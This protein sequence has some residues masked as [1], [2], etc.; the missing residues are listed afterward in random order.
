MKIETRL[1][2]LSVFVVIKSRAD[3]T[4]KDT[5]K[6]PQKPRNTAP[7]LASSHVDGSCEWTFFNVCNG[8]KMV[9]NLLHSNGRHL[10]KE[11]A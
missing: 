7:I 10:I 2:S 1:N 8:L 5:I 9:V 6:K 4:H 11:R 3:S